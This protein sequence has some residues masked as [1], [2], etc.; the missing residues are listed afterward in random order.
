MRSDSNLKA[1]KFTPYDLSAYMKLDDTALR[2][3]HLFPSSTG[4]KHTSLYGLLNECKTVQ[5][6]RLLEQWIRQPLLSKEMIENRLD[7]VEAFFECSSVR[8]GLREVV[9]RAMPDLARIIRRLVRGS[10]NL[11]DIVVLYQAIAKIPPI[12]EELSQADAKH[13][14]VLSARYV[15]P[16][17]ALLTSLKP[18][19]EM[20]E[21]MVD[22]AALERHEY[23]VRADFDEGLQEV[24]AQKEAILEAIEPEFMEAAKDLGLEANKKIKLERNNIHGYYLRVSRIDANLIKGGQY[25]ELAALKNGVYFVTPHLRELS[26]RYDELCRLYASKQSVLVK[27]ML[28]ITASFRPLFDQYNLV[29]A[30][31]DVA[32]SL[33]YVS[34]MSPKSFVRPQ[35]G[36]PDLVLKGA[37]HPCLEANQSDFIPNDVEFR[38]DANCMQII[39]GPNMGGKSTYIRQAALCIIMAQIGCFIPA[40]EAQVPVFDAVMVRV[41]AGDNI[42]RG[43]STFMAEMLETASILRTAT[44]DTFVVI[45]ELGRGTSTSEGLG[46]AWGVTKYLAT[47]IGCFAFFATHFHELTVLADELPTLIKNL[48]VSAQ[49]H[50]GRLTMMYAVQPGVCDESFGIHVAEL[51]NFPRLVVEM[52]RMRVAELESKPILPFRDEAEMEATAHFVNGL[53]PKMAEGRR[54]GPADFEGAPAVL[55]DL[56]RECSR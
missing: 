6:S 11:Q 39:T 19:A 38:R 1:F 32:M 21:K 41:G 53:K 22:F 29:I 4:P 51:A 28:E 49:I 36:G 3:L 52:A 5:G 9:L 47:K 17:E 26:I 23:I 40:D 54:F 16:L 2:S 46:L 7:V 50:D 27:E 43:I 24:A 30:D 14:N 33:A 34:L 55:Q 37:R 48:H 44:R 42:L 10:C 18:F 45:D 12:L 56:L 15:A 25:Q 8:Q 31:L 13:K 35:V 20:V